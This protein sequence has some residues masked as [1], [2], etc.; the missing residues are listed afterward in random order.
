MIRRTVPLSLELTVRDVEPEDLPALDWSGGPA[1]I[2]ALAAAWQRTLEDEVVLL[3]L[4]AANGRLVAVGAV[5]LVKET[6]TGELWMLSVH[7]AW[8]SLGVGSRLIAALEDATRDHGHTDVQLSV[9]DDN[10]RAAALYARLGYRA[11][12]RRVESWPLDD[13]SLWTTT[14][15]VLRRALDG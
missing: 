4:Q 6:G 8:Q 14:T 11:V 3:G 9:E 13:G 2:R 12:G 10:P 7:E 1:H 15:T 5:D